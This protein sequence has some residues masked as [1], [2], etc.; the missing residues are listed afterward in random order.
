MWEENWYIDLENTLSDHDKEHN[1]VEC[2]Q[3]IP[4]TS[5][6]LDKQYIVIAW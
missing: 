5:V 6:P 3:S 4:T 2:N 1:T